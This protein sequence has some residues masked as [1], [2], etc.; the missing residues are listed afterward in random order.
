MADNPLLVPGDDGV[1]LLELKQGL[2]LYLERPPTREAVQRVYTLYLKRCGQSIRRYRSTAPGSRV[3]VWDEA[4]RQDFEQCEL[5]SLYRQRDWGW[6]FSDGQDVDSWMFM[7]HGQRRHSQAG[8]ASFFRF[9]FDWRLAPEFLQDL[10]DELIDGTEFFWGTGG[11]YL[12]GRADLRYLAQSSDLA[13]ATA[14]RYWGAEAHNLDVTVEYALK[15][16]K[17]VNWLTMVGNALASRF[18]QALEQ[19]RAV[20]YR[21]HRSACGELFQA[22]FYPALGDRHAGDRLDGYVSLAK[23]LEPLQTTEHGALGGDRWTEENTMEYLRRFTN[24][25]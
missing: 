6:M 23:A 3:K 21:A 22:Q 25:P 9:D 13:Y 11:Y 18:P 2:V 17:C 8:M 5:P 10:A 16:L 7:F 14:R 15:G 1:P 12:Q 4:A 19:A 24:S 20:A